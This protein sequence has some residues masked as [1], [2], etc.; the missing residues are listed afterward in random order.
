MLLYP[1]DKNRVG[2]F[3]GQVDNY[4]SSANQTKLHQYDL[5]ASESPSNC[6][7]KK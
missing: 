2:K 7:I 1:I 5:D 4:I 3:I 6:A